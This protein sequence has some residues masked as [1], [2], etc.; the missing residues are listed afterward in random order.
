MI[1]RRLFLVFA[2]CFLLAVVSATAGTLVQFRTTLGD[3]VVELY[4]RD[5]PVTV[6]NFLRYVDAGRYTNIFFH[7]CIPGFV[8][9]GGGFGV[10]DPASTNALAFYIPVSAYDAI[11]NEFAVGPRYSN[12]YGTIAMAK[13]TNSPD[14]ATCQWFFNL[15]DNSANLDNQNGGFT[16]FGRVIKGTNVLTQFNSRSM[17]NGIVNLDDGLFSALPVTFSGMIWPHYNE[18]IYVTVQPLSV[19]IRGGCAGQCS[20][21]WAGVAGMTNIVEYA[22]TLSPESWN[23]LLSTNPANGLLNIAEPTTGITSRLYRIRVK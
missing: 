4:D 21:Q 14:T 7:R 9:Q 1:S 8:A 10:A 5:K 3:M 6:A 17:W 19:E 15:A 12:V 23:F 13:T 22:D 20:L 18:L 11:T 2:H 16:V